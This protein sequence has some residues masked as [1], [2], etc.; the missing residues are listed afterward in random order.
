MTE[1][2]D[3]RVQAGVR[4]RTPA[5]TYAGPKLEARQRDSSGLVAVV[6]PSNDMDLYS[7]LGECYSAIAVTESSVCREARD[8]ACVEYAEEVRA[9]TEESSADG[10]SAEARARMSTRTE[11]RGQTGSDQCAAG[12][13]GCAECDSSNTA[14]ARCEAEKRLEGSQCVDGIGV[15]LGRG[16]TADPKSCSSTIT[17]CAS[18]TN[19]IDIQN[20]GVT[21]EV[22]TKC[23][24]T[25]VPIDGACDTIANA[26]SKCTPPSAAD[27]TCK[28]CQGSHYLFSGGCYAA[29]PDGYYGDSNTCKPCS[30]I[31]GCSTCSSGTVCTKCDG[32]KI[33]KT[34]N[35]VTS[36]VT[37]EECTKAE[38]FFVKGAD[39]SKTC[40]ACDSTCK[41]CSGGGEAD[42]CTS[43]K[44]TGMIYLK[45]DSPAGQTGTCVDAAGCPSTHYIDEEAKTCST[46]AS[47]GTTGCKTCAK[48]DGV[49]ACASCE[50]SQK[51]GLNK[52]SCVT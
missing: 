10:T 11:T 49:V 8:G 14:C 30:T 12:T 42:K 51:F 33:V 26:N 50:D 17:N 39:G 37:E 6:H 44:D 13:N 28:S 48:T 5:A 25:H 3:E 24:N 31:A 41:T 9:E 16:L 52:K 2:R 32:G 23:E 34:D 1:C 18:G 29:C 40:E 20:N 15:P 21:K 22:C 7:S 19:C 38:G 4:T 35:G 46:C 45:K 47:A 36:C 43:C 27:G